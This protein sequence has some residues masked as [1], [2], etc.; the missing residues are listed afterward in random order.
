[1]SFMLFFV[2]YLLFI[3]FFASTVYTGFYF[4]KKQLMYKIDALPCP[5]I[6]RKPVKYECIWA[7][8]YTAHVMLS[9]V[10]P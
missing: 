10:S 2:I 1:M 4:K 3:L 7:F 6:K 5:A 9:F 8:M